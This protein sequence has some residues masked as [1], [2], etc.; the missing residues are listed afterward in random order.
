M[1]T[2]GGFPPELFTFFEGLHED[3]SKDYWNANK[4]VWHEQVRKPMLTLLCELREEFGPMRMFR[5][6][7]DVR[8][9]K[10]K[11]PYKLW[12][13]AT[14]ESRAVGGIGYYLEVSTAGIVTGYGAMAMARD[15]LQRFRA[16]IDEATS[17]RE[18]EKLRAGLT[19]RSLPITSGIDPP[20]N[21]APSGYLSTHPRSEILR[22]KGAAVVQQYDKADWIHT[23]LALDKIRTI[24]S[25][26]RPLKDWL[27]RHIGPTEDPAKSPDRR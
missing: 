21:R 25:G 3:N 5:P 19:R 12:A 17:G 8:F 26:A 13:G 27:D 4:T 7:R 23:P 1:S 14:S 2:F 20:L 24:W 15:Q 11:S 18:F 6:N 10:D 22:W 16:A 9:A